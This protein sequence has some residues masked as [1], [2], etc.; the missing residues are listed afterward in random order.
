MGII[1]KFKNFKENRHKS[2]LAKNLKLITNPK[3]IKEDRSSSIDYFKS[4]ES[5]EEAVPA[6][7]QRFNFSLEHGIND[8]REK[9]SAMEGII[10]FGEE[11]KPLI[12]SHLQKSDKI[13]WPIKTFKAIGSKDELMEMLHSC[14][15][16]GE[17]SFD[18]S[19]VDKNYDI[20]CYLRDFKL[21]KKYVDQIFHFLEQ[22]DER[23]RFSAIELIVEQEDSAIP[24]KI[25]KFLLD[26]SAENTRIRQVTLEAFAEK[27]WPLTNK[28]AFTVGPLC[29][30]YKV[31]SSYTI[32]KTNR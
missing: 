25:E 3:A 5:C 22:H 15:D 26:D 7:L 19:R 12:N 9:E 23:L 14:L 21:P 16:Y 17:V 10:K 13:A 29:P 1:S 8:T 18:Q 31:S 6:L 11:A 30:G 27:K 2:A 28:S 24:A 32:E 4:L 20:I